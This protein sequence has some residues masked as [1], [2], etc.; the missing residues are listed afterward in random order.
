DGFE[1]STSQR[2]SNVHGRVT[3]PGSFTAAGDRLSVFPSRYGKGRTYTL[4]HTMSRPFH[5]VYVPLTGLV[6]R[7]PRLL[8]L[9]TSPDRAHHPDNNNLPAAAP[10]P[11]MQPQTALAA[12]AQSGASP[13]GEA[14]SGPAAGPGEGQ[15]SG[16]D[17][18]A[19]EPLSGGGAG[20]GTPP[21][22][23]LAATTRPTSPPNSR[24]TSSRRPRPS[25]TSRRSAHHAALSTTPSGQW[26]A[27]PTSSN[28]PL[29]QV[30]R[31]RCAR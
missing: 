1:S 29:S 7:A 31:R 27:L 22:P 12:Q 23:H 11:A 28:R 25:P 13:A 6:E 20:P 9:P 4:A 18:R 19:A 8:R 24:E 15:R 26:P 17:Q 16:H 3:A 2:T 5:Q 30:P 10:A 14:L 21:P